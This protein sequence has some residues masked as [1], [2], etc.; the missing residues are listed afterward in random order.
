MTRAA[1]LLTL[2]GPPCG[3]ATTPGAGVRAVMTD[4]LTPE[5]WQHIDAAEVGTTATAYLDAAA[6]AITAPRIQS[7]QLLGVEPGATVLDVGCGTGIGAAR[8]RRST[9]VATARSSDSTPALRCSSRHVRA[10]RVPR[11]G[12][13][14]SRA[15]PRA[16]ASRA[17]GSMPCAP[18]AS[19]CT[20][21][22]AGRGAGRARSGD[23]AGRARRAHRARSPSARPRHRN[24]RCV[25]AVHA[26]VP[27]NAPETSAR[28]FVRHPTPRSGLEPR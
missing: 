6:A 3:G 24:A 18:S 17:N 8:D 22:P 12:S 5:H 16:R 7:H 27:P 10:S 26:G 4:D 23:S 20:S 13:N 15:R 1:L 19:S 28:A 25:G 9:S 11:H 2:D 21:H 14:S